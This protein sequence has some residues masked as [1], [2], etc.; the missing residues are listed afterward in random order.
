MTTT[1]L[2]DAAIP[3]CMHS[4][5]DPRPP[6]TAPKTNLVAVLTHSTTN[7]TLS[8][9]LSDLTN[10]L[11]LLHHYQNAN[12]F[13]SARS[14]KSLSVDFSAYPPLLAKYL[15]LTL[16]NPSFVAFLQLPHNLQHGE[17]PWQEVPEID[18]SQSNAVILS[19]IEFE[20]GYNT[21]RIEVEFTP[22]TTDQIISELADRARKATHLQR[23]LVDEQ[24]QNSTLRA[25]N[26]A[27]TETVQRNAAKLSEM[28]ATNEQVE[29]LTANLTDVKAKLQTALSD[30]QQ[31]Q[32]R[33]SEAARLAEERAG[34]VR[35]LEAQLG[36]VSRQTRSVADV[37]RDQERRMQAVVRQRDEAAE[38][39]R[40]GNTI[41]QSLQEKVR[42]QQA[43]IKR[44]Q[45]DM[46]ALRAKGKVKDA[47]IAKQE[48]KVAS[49][50]RECRRASDRVALLQ[51]EKDG[52]DGRL[53]SA[54]A[55]LE[56]NKAVIDS[57]QQVISY[58]NRELND[59][60]L[61]EVSGLGVGADSGRRS[62]GSSG[63]R[64]VSPPG[65]IVRD[66]IGA[67]TSTT[68]AEVV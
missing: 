5:P 13:P 36:D 11:L 25:Q 42:A 9:T 28:T 20:Q 66:V 47:V 35:E 44:I 38:Q 23:R 51:V 22:A 57:D 63:K 29:S 62:G 17:R 30:L 2:F 14:P 4:P 68:P 65:D 39:I 37:E 67:R 40:R 43:D 6:S 46:R 8:L 7:S 49:L 15:N 59:R 55:K 19:I 10:R 3:V 58:L 26:G 18:T 53:T 61:S 21:T 24:A 54:Y 16:S 50:Q 45:A 1:T 34:R 12:N 56:E 31:L 32:V 52:L 27:L 33:E 64:S 48:E 60:L 41:I